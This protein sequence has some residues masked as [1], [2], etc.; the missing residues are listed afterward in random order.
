MSAIRIGQATRPLAVIGILCIIIIVLIK[1]ISILTTQPTAVVQPLTSVVSGS[2]PTVQL[3][4]PALLRQVLV[5]L[6]QAAPAMVQKVPSEP[7]GYNQL[8]AKYMQQARETGDFG[9]NAKAESALKY[10]FK[11]APDNYKAIEL[12]AVLLL[13]YHQFSEALTVARQAQQLRPRDPEVY[14]A[15]TDALVELGD[16]EGANTAVQTMLELRPNST[17]YARLSY[18]RTLHGDPEGAITAMRT[19]AK[20]ANPRDREGVAWYRLQLGN[21]L[22][23]AGSLTEGEREVD[24]ALH[25]FP[26]YHLALATKA[27]A[28]IAAGDL[29][30]AVNFYQQAQERVPLPDTA[31]ALGNL[32]TYLGYR[33]QA[34]R[35]YDLVEFIER[36]GTAISQTYSR[37]LALFWANHNMKLDEA[38]VIAQREQLTRS[39]IY[40]FDVLAWCLFKQGKLPEAKT[41]ID[42]ALR[43]GTRD[44]RIYYH[45]GM[46]HHGLGDRLKAGNYLKL[47]LQTNPSF[48]ILQ[49]DIA[50]Q[51][52]KSFTNEKESG[53]IALPLFE[54]TR[55]L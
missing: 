27:R 13:T 34:Q 2:T 11:V 3:Q 20:V 35:Q 53:G 23:N 45:A 46:I 7:D 21:E 48:D 19:A 47:A 28:R 16:Y 41:A 29:E 12:Q 40:T 39:D 14:G 32:Y 31:I 18:L 24:I 52:L 8:A 6:I 51:T 42:S 36:A 54:G 43:L 49:A 17:A 25:S 9:L 37:E 5:N 26:N 10:S 4:A 44:A 50:R 38:L 55:A 15:M 22:M 33:E 1:T 30:S